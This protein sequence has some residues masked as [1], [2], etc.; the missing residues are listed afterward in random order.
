MNIPESGGWERCGWRVQR[1]Q[2]FVVG[3]AANFVRVSNATVWFVMPVDVYEDADDET[4]AALCRHFAQQVMA[5]GAGTHIPGALHSHPDRCR[6][7]YPE[8]AHTYSGEPGTYE[9]RRCARCSHLRPPV[10]ES[11]TCHPGDRARLDE[12][13]PTARVFGEPLPD[14]TLILES[15]GVQLG[16]LRL[17]IEGEDM[18]VAFPPPPPAPQRWIRCDQFGLPLGPTPAS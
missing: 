16:T 3:E 17:R 15:I 11:I 5:G 18:T 2:H 12:Q 4:F 14:G 13:L 8:D 10:L 9:H 1:P 7:G 6:P